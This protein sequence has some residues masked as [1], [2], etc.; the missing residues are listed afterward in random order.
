MLVAGTKIF[1]DSG[2]K[3]VEEISGQDKVLVR[4]FIGDAEFI[5]PFAVKK[6]KYDGQVVKTGGQN[7]SFTVTPDHEVV[8]GKRGRL[9]R[10]FKYMFSDEPKKEYIT[11]RDDFGERTVTISDYDWYKLV[12]YVLT[13]GFIRTGYG[14]PMLWLFLEED[15]VEEEILILGD[16]LDRIGLGWHV[17]YSE[18]TRPKLVVSSK[19]TLARRLITRLGS[20]TRKSMSLS[21]KMVYAS[22]RELTQLLIETIISSSIK[23]DTKRGVNYQLS[24]TNLALIDSLCLFGELGGYGM[25]KKLKSKAGSPAPKGKTQKDSYILQISAPTALVSPKYQEISLYSGYIYGIDLFYGEIYVKE[26]QQAIWI[27]PK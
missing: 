23:P 11:I 8:Y 21:A 13:R 17:Q 24:T 26:G 10:K 9:N 2:W 5:Q 25:R 15:R 12:G 6:R 7:W 18:K 22:S 19:N 4:N 16:I 27:T 14:K 1:T 3:Q 20:S